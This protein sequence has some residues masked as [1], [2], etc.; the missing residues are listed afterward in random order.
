MIVRREVCDC[1]GCEKS[2]PPG[3]QRVFVPTGREMDASGNGYDEEGE[4]LDLCPECLKYAL[5][6]Y[7]G[8][9]WDKNREFLAK[10]KH[11]RQSKKNWKL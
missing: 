3:I 4:N 5:E 11:R 1:D 10:L 8:D 7:A 2:E 9:C 6:F